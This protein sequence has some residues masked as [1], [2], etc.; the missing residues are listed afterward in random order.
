VPK[1]PE[2]AA[3]GYSRVDGTVA[4]YQR[5]NALIHDQPGPVTI[6]DFGAGR[7]ESVDDPLP[8][9]RELRDLRGAGRRVVGVDVDPAVHENPVVDEAH[10][11][12]PDGEIPLPDGSVDVIVSRYT[13]EHIDHPDAVVAEMGRVLRPAGWICAQTPN[14]WGYIALGARLVPNRLHVG[15][16]RRLQPWKQER[17]T[18]PTRYRM[19]TRRDIRRLFPSH[20]YAVYAY[21]FDA[22]PDLYA[23]GS[24]LVAGAIGALTHVPGPFKSLWDVFIQKR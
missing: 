24:R 9:R 3:G 12:G 17:D 21:T 11:V 2:T 1:F 4:F 23:G 20:S 6:V 22:E 10:V 18:F 5:V 19:N 8:F 7:G 16:L 14:R 15:S 13:W